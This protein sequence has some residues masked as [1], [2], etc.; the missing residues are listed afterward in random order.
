M[1]G[2][3]NWID[4]NKYSKGFGSLEGKDQKSRIFIKP[5]EGIK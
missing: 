5:L 3:V 1:R 4:S 2:G